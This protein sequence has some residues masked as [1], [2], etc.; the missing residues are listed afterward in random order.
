V[1]WPIWGADGTIK[2]H[3]V[4]RDNPEIED[5][6]PK[7]KYVQSGDRSHLFFERSSRVH[8]ND[9]GVP[10]IFVEAASSVLA[11]AAWSERTGRKFLVIATHGCGSWHGTI[12]ALSNENG[13]RVSEK[14]PLPDLD[15]IPFEKREVF[16]LFDSNISTNENVKS[17]ARKFTRVLQENGATVRIP[18]IPEE[19]GNGPDDHLACRSDEDFSALLASAAMEPSYEWPFRLTDDSVLRRIDDEDDETGEKTKEWRRI[20]SYLE[21]DSETRDIHGEKTG[22][23]SSS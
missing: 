9:V 20:C 14:G 13:V 17:Q 11:I 21:V 3:R 8:L 18:V 5:G 7:A 22:A 10:V 1:D 23:V 19:C 15:L 4:R 6:K 16:I 2:G 12:G